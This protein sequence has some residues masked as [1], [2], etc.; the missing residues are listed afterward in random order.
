[1]LL[2]L[3]VFSH[4]SLKKPDGEPLECTVGWLIVIMGGDSIFVQLEAQLRESTLENNEAY[5]MDFCKRGWDLG[6]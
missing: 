6:M 4:L 1:M 3:E 5:Q 2:D